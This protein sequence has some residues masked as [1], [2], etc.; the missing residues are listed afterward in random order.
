MIEENIWGMA[1]RT[2]VLKTC[3]YKLPSR[4]GETLERLYKDLIVTQALGNLVWRKF[5]KQPGD[6]WLPLP[7]RT[8]SFLRRRSS[9]FQFA[10][11]LYGD[12][13]VQSYRL[14]SCPGAVVTA[15]TGGNTAPG[16]ALRE[17]TATSQ[18]PLL[19]PRVPLGD[20]TLGAGYVRSSMAGLDVLTR[21]QP[22]WGH[23]CGSHRWVSLRTHV[24]L[25][26][27]F[28]FLLRKGGVM[29]EE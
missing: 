9:L 17:D 5:V 4:E 1:N 10:W 2:D 7:L 20:A 11:Q 26:A 19:R 25:G 23:G 28:R 16:R 29:G 21:Q 24:W 8:L 18:R 12:V 14:A 27:C 22:R 13:D 6:G 15:E 3:Q